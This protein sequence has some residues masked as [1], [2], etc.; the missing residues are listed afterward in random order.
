[1][2]QNRPYSVAQLT[3]YIKHRLESDDLLRGVLV[4]GEISNLTNHRSGHV[5]FSLKDKEAQVSCVMWR[6]TAQRYAGSLP[7]HG[8]QIVAR[9][10]ISVYPPRGSYQLVVTA[11]QKA[12]LGD[13]HQRFLELKER[14]NKEGLF[15]AEHKKS[16]PHFPKRIGVVTSPTGSV[17]RDILDTIRRRYPHVEVLLVPTAVQGASAAPDIARNIRRL[18]ELDNL[19]IIILGRGGGSLEDLWCFNEEVVARAVFACETPLI[20]AIGH[21]TD[22]TIADFVA[23]RRAATPTAAA[24]LA[25]PMAADIKNYLNDSKQRFSQQ[26]Q[27]FIEYRRQMLDDFEDR[28]QAGLRSHIGQYRLRLADLKGQLHTSME[29]TFSQKRHDL[30]K[31]EMAFQALDMRSVLHRG[32]SITLKD[33]KIVKDGEKLA[34][35]DEIETVF[36]KGRVKSR[37]EKD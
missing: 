18:D 34:D 3:N 27:Q 32:Y 10:Q 36:E 26:L 5:Y 2:A 31:L 13:L 24:E 12:G 9:G 17:I 28:F 11:I 16:I 20:T 7:K 15:A 19:D 33:G 1:M 6:S 14:L 21:E 4:G 8:E 29:R 30:E 37:V 35:G 23:D 25:V 22:T